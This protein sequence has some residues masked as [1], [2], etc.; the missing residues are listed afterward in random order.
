MSHRTIVNLD[1]DVAADNLKFHCDHPDGSR[2]YSL[3]HTSEV[4]TYIN[5]E[6][7]HELVS[8]GLALIQ[9]AELWAADEARR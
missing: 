5:V 7:R 4:I 8:F 9:A 2:T 3:G 6:H 1:A